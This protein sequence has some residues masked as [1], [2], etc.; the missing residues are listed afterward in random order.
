LKVKIAGDAAAH[1]EALQ[2]VLEK[3]SPSV[4]SALYQAIIVSENG[5]K[6]VLAALD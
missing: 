6:E 1:L 3:A 4:R 2:S 5:Y